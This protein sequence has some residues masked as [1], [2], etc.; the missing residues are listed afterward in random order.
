MSSGN[1]PSSTNLITLKLKALQ[2]ATKALQHILSSARPLSAI[3]EESTQAVRHYLRIAATHQTLNAVLQ[4]THNHANAHY[5]ALNKDFASVWAGSTEVVT[6]A[7]N[8]KSLAA[9]AIHQ[10]QATDT[11]VGH[12]H[13]M[14]G[15]LVELAE[16][17][18][19]EEKVAT[20]TRKV[21][22]ILGIP[23]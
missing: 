15:D 12:I 21:K 19:G 7:G 17:R 22:G 18:W 23:Q 1:T 8:I 5:Q 20:E 3:R 2:A 10:A 9:Q 13:N 16:G 6:G 11:L 14:L 4:A